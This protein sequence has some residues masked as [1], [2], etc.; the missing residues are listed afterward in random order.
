MFAAESMEEPDAGAPRRIEPIV[1]IEP[2]GVQSLPVERE[3]GA[4]MAIP[5]PGGDA[6][7]PEQVDR[8][9][10]VA[11]VGSVRETRGDA[12]ETRGWHCQL[13]RDQSPLRR[14]R[15]RQWKHPHADQPWP[16]LQ[17]PAL[18][19][20]E[21]QAD[22]RD[23]PRIH[24]PPQNEGSRVKWHLLTNSRSE[25]VFQY[26]SACPFRAFAELRLGAEEMETPVPGLDARR[27]G[28]LVHTALEEF[29]K[30]VRT[31]DAL[32]SRGDIGEVI[33]ASVRTALD[34]LQRDSSGVD[35]PQRFSELESR[36][37]ERLLGG[38]LEIERQRSAF[39]VIQ[40]EGERYADRK[41]TR[42]NSSHLVISYAVFCLKKKKHSE[43]TQTNMST[44]GDTN[45]DDSR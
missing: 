34:R 28:T 16:R 25:P 26:Q 9:T 21:G 4:A 27:R 37:L 44:R 14:S 22:G 2:A 45:E 17:E 8:P 30:E 39:E 24:R 5:L 29:W 31:H 32:C 35:L 7:L 19:A 3:P 15:G 10:E 11:A 23:E 18:S 42:L 40:P 41:S 43:K 13:L 36:R 38:W 12:A 33:R 6:Q 1:P 20:A